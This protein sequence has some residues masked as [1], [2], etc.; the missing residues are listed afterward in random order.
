[1]DGGV[2]AQLDAAV[3]KINHVVADE[4]GIAAPQ[5]G[6]AAG[7]GLVGVV[8]RDAVAVD[9]ERAAAAR[10]DDDAVYC[11]AVYVVV[12]GERVAG[13][14]RIG[15]RVGAE[16]QSIAEA[17]G[18]VLAVVLP[19]PVILVAPVDVATGGRV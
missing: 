1:G 8:D 13:E 17:G 18:G 2:A 10:I 11:Q 15:G 14:E 3:E 6:D 9:R 19:D 16:D 5:V 12:A 4:R 7:V